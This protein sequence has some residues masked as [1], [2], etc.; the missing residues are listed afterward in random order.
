[1]VL[2]FINVLQSKSPQVEEKTV[3]G[4]E[5]GMF[6]NTVTNELYEELI[7][8]PASREHVMLEFV[9][10]DNGGGFRGKH[11]YDSDFVQKTLADREA[12]VGSKGRVGKIPL[13]GRGEKGNEETEMSETFT[14]FGV[15]LTPDGKQVVGPVAIPFRSKK[16]K[17]Y[18]KW[19]SA[20]NTY[21][22]PT[23]D[24]GRVRPPFWS[25]VVRLKTW[26]DPSSP[27]GKF[28][29]ITFEPAFEGEVVDGQGKGTGKKL[30]MMSASILGPGD[31]RYE[32]AK[33]IAK[34]VDSGEAKVDYTNAPE[35][36]EAH[37]ED[38]DA[39]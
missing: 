5:P 15:L 34:L 6:F 22:H 3:K 29:N 12:K 38:P 13:S 8:I 10:R 1:M 2:P 11:A 30:P 16:I 7:F 35:A 28:F 33:K 32:E 26:L 18:K 20:Q 25:H 39:I 4:A 21:L 27:K 19:R 9:P 31:V 23:P 17:P 24:G 37:Y 14:V 36:G